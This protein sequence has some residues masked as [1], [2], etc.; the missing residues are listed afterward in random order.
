MKRMI[1]IFLLLILSATVASSRSYAGNPDEAAFVQRELSW[2]SRSEIASWPEPEP[3][4]LDDIVS[5]RAN[6]YG[7]DLN[8]EYGA[9]FRQHI[10]KI[11]SLQINFP[12]TG[13]NRPLTRHITFEQGSLLPSAESVRTEDREYASQK[14]VKNNAAKRSPK[15]E[16]I[17]T[18]KPGEEMLKEIT[19]KSL[20]ACE[21]STV[22][23]LKNQYQFVEGD[24]E[25]RFDLLYL[26][27]DP[28]FSDSGSRKL[29]YQ[30]L[31]GRRASV[32]FYTT[33]PGDVYSLQVAKHGGSCLPYRV[34]ITG[35]KV[36]LLSGESALKNFDSDEN[37][38]LHPTV[39]IESKKFM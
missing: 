36:Y 17:S 20:S 35:E 23:V 27:G 26:K 9:R 6:K 39:K 1:A 33:E 15:V 5:K 30:E 7:V 25:V 28:E 34:R 38:K 14:A 21:S 18:V 11:E 29:D 12:T 37:G 13:S 4:S 16:V 8:T 22:S 31:F 10:S 32:W 2:A 24:K 3:I 19:P